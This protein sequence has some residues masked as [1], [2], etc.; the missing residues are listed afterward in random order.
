MKMVLSADKEGMFHILD[1]DA[2]N[3]DQEYF[4]LCGINHFYSDVPMN[5]G[6]VDEIDW[7]WNMPTCTRR[8]LFGSFFIRKNKDSI[9]RFICS[10]EQRLN[11]PKAER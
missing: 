6:K 4:S 5:L 10:R 1:H 7:F 9:Q 11:K 8:Q 2:F 3:D